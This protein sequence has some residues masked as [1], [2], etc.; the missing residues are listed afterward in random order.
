MPQRQEVGLLGRGGGADTPWAPVPIPVDVDGG[1]P[2]VLDAD[3]ADI[4]NKYEEE[5]DDDDVDDVGMAV[6]MIGK[7]VGDSGACQ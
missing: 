7:A 5:D 1:E 6:L 3:D 4:I 2:S